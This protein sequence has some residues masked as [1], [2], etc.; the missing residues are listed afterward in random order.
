MALLHEPDLLRWRRK[1][2]HI[3]TVSVTPLYEEHG[4]NAVP[5]KRME[6]QKHMYSDRSVEYS[7]C[8]DCVCHAQAAKTYLERNFEDF[9]AAD[10]D[11]LLQHSLKVRPASLQAL[12]ASRVYLCQPCQSPLCRLSRLVA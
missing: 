12:T 7:L 4:K 6:E 9:A 5:Y 1:Q 3:W 8:E 11:A 10:V 2:R